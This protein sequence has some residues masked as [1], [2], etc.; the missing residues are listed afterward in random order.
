MNLVQEAADLPGINPRYKHGILRT[1]SDV[2]IKRSKSFAETKEAVARPRVLSETGT[3]ELNHKNCA[4]HIGHTIFMF[5]SF[6][7][8]IT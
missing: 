1:K 2:A 6:W 8:R 7:Y 3:G 4:N 5:S